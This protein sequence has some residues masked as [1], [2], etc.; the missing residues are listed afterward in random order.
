[1]SDTGSE[2]SYESEDVYY[3]VE[4]YVVEEEDGGME[5]ATASN[6]DLAS[7][8]GLGLRMEDPYCDD[9]IADEEWTRKY[10]EEMEEEKRRNIELENRFN[11]NKDV[12]SW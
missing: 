10:R 11:G 2:S 6:D 3:D 8:F 4:E 1:M 7:S 12:Y 9:P 5:Q